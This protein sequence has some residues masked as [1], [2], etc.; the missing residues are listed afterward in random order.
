MS[1]PVGELT[2]DPDPL[3]ERVLAN[4][5]QILQQELANV[6]LN[7]AGTTLHLANTA[8]IHLYADFGEKPSQTTFGFKADVSDGIALSYKNLTL[9]KREDLAWEVKHAMARQSMLFDS[10]PDNY[11]EYY[12]ESRVFMTNQPL[13]FEPHDHAMLIGH[14]EKLRSERLRFEASDIPS[15][16]QRQILL[17]GFATFM[18]YLKR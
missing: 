7:T 10:N 2:I 11:E 13:F 9:I 15:H 8:L 12:H 14:W 18:S 17:G 6:T 16:E 5:E 3:P 4:Y 1:K